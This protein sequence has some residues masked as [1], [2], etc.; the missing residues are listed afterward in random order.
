MLTGKRPCDPSTLIRWRKFNLPEI[1]WVDERAPTNTTGEDFLTRFHFLRL[2]RH[3]IKGTRFG[4]GQQFL[5]LNLVITRH[6][7][8]ICL[9]LMETK[10]TTGYCKWYRLQRMTIEVSGFSEISP[11]YSQIPESPDP[12]V[13]GRRAGDTWRITAANWKL[14]LLR[15]KGIST[16]NC[17]ENLRCAHPLTGCTTALCHH[18]SLLY[19]RIFGSIMVSVPATIAR[20]YCC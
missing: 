10:V 9:I 16:A 14:F 4:N 5:K 6:Q 17:D 7:N 8:A 1:S 2:T 15:V 19:F 12:G 20:N 18:F 13:E 3:V 11:E